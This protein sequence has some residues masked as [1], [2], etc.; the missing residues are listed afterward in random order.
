M[1]GIRRELTGLNMLTH[2]LNITVNDDEM[3]RYVNS[4]AR[5]DLAKICR[6]VSAIEER[7]EKLDQKFNTENYANVMGRLQNLEKETA[8]KI[9]KQE[10]TYTKLENDIGQLNVTI[11]NCD[12]KIDNEVSKFVKNTAGITKG[13]SKDTDLSAELKQTTD[14]VKCLG[15]L[16][17]IA[18]TFLHI[19]ARSGLIK[20]V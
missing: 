4:E 14:Q 15:H 8:E 19:F 12:K 5:P 17:S 7:L 11:S 16:M 9:S 20:Y 1:P 10:A 2:N 13:N 18:E 6:N 3:T